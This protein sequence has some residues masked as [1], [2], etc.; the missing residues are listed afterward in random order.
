MSSSLLIL[1]CLAALFL[2]VF[3]SMR[4]G[5]NAGIPAAAFAYFLGV[6]LGD[7]SITELIGTFPTHI[8]FVLLS[9]SMFFGYASKNG[10]LQLLA[11]RVVY[12]TRK[13]RWAP[14]L[15]LYIAA[16]LI[17]SAGGGTGATLLF[18]APIGFEISELAGFHP[19]LVPLAISMASVS[20]DSMFWSPGFATRLAY[21]DGIYSPEQARQI[22]SAVSIITLI[23]YFVVYLVYY[24]V[25]KGYRTH[26]TEQM[27]PPAA[28]NTKQKQTF[29]ILIAVIA[30]III[31]S[32]L[33]QVI[34]SPV[35][36]F[37]AQ[38]C[39]IQMLSIVGSMLCCLLRLGDEGDI[40]KNFV[41]WSIIV[42]SGGVTMLISVATNAGLTE[43]LTAW[44]SAAVPQGV[45]YGLVFF[46]CG[47]LSFFSGYVV[48][49]PLVLPLLPGVAAATGCSLV[50][51]AVGPFIGGMITGMSPISIG[52]AM[53]LGG[54]A[55]EKKR[56]ALFLPQLLTGLSLWGV[57]NI[58]AF[59][60]VVTLF[61]IYS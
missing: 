41:P 11:Y 48:V 61:G 47:A 35:L 40:L 34:D 7:M 44:L 25:F 9:T 36:R 58:L 31:P 4:T 33:S 51:L 8:L 18:L 2:S 5:C 55:D 59:T 24:F 54:C 29:C 45:T 30:L 28:F 1:S 46:I 60:P 49:W 13:V 39:D 6:L 10:T 14:A 56:Q 26:G 37:L 50:G 53:I 22:C 16:F 38:K 43:L 3:L 23:L 19:L 15:I 21:M 52:G 57:V 12:A 17:A 42:L 20:G 32:M 27:Q